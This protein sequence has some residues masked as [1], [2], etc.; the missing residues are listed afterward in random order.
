MHKNGEITMNVAQ[1]TD[2]K[3][4]NDMRRPPKEQDGYLPP[5]DYQTGDTMSTSIPSCI[6]RN[7]LCVPI[8]ALTVCCAGFCCI[9]SPAPNAGG[10]SYMCDNTMWWGSKTICCCDYPGKK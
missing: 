1:F 3:P 5:T 10:Y 4:P 7:I 8:S 9:V 2:P 6:F